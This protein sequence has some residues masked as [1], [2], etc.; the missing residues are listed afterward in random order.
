[1]NTPQDTQTSSMPP[2]QFD[3]V[4]V[5]SEVL[6]T[7]MEREIQ[8]SFTKWSK[9]FLLNH[10]WHL[11]RHSQFGGVK[12]RNNRQMCQKRA[13]K[14]STFTQQLRAAVIRLISTLHVAINTDFYQAGRHDLHMGYEQS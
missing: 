10:Q 6:Q 14:K 11:T 13:L 8:Q 5:A 2:F 1:M 9:E 7:A 12:F 4:C 3:S